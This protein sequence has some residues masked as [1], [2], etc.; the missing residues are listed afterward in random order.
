MSTI[1]LSDFADWLEKYGQAWEFGDAEG[2]IQLFTEDASYHE[3]PFD[4]P[5]KGYEAIH[6]YWIEGASQSQKDVHFSAHVLA[7]GEDLRSTVAGGI[8]PRSIWETRFP[9]WCA[10]GPL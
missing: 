8:L 6:R 1:S 2:V 5:M 9:G 3:T 4:N 7:V 10:F